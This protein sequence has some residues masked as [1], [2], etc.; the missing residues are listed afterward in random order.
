[1]A[2]RK[3]RSPAAAAAPAPMPASV[4]APVSAPEPPAGAP[5]QGHSRP[6]PLLLAAVLLL[7]PAVGV[8]NE[9]MLQD[10]LKSIVVSFG[11]LGAALVFLLQ[12]R[13]DPQP[14]LWHPVLWLPLLLAAYALGSMAWSHAYLAGVEAIRWFVFALLLWLSLNTLDRARLPVVFWGVH[15]GAVLAAT[16]A[17]LQFWVDWRGFPQG[18]PPASTFVN[19][20]FFAE[21]VVCTLPFSVLLLARLRQ[22]AAIALMAASVALVIV[23]VLMTCTRAA[24]FAMWLQLLIVLP[25]ILWR[26]RDRLAWGGWGTARRA[27]AAGVLLAGVLGMGLVPSGN[28]RLLAEGRGAT[29]LERG[30]KRTAS[31]SAGDASVGIRLLM[32]RTTGRMIADRPLTG[33]GAGAWEVEAPLYMPRD[34]QL[35]ADYYVHNEVL[36]ALAEYGLSGLVFLLGLFAWLLQAAWRTWREEGTDAA[37]EGPWRASALCGLLALLMVSNAGFPW[38]MAATGALFAIALGIVAASDARLRVPGR[39]AP[40]SLR[41]TRGRATAALACAGACTVLAAYIAQQAAACERMIVEAARIALQVSASGRPNAP[42]WAADKARM[43][44]LTREA[45][46]INPHY[47]KITPMVADELAGLGDWQNAAWIWQSVLA[48]RPHVVAIL[49]NVARAHTQLGRPQEAF[50]A[51][52]HAK[53]IS[54]DAPAV[55]SLEVILLSRHGQDARAL[56][57]AGRAMDQ[58]FYDVDLLRNAFLLGWRAGDEALLARSMELLLRDFPAVRPDSLLLLADYQWRGLQDEAKAVESWR[59]ALSTAPAARRPAI[60]AR[61]PPPLRP[62]VER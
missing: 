22:T 62:R 51:L 52:E 39:A 58:G 12:R 45:V 44:Q 15:G 25:W 41:W 43:L 59:L 2:R 19:R 27:L 20:N 56:E 26:Y 8:P 38:R 50:R 28:D 32:W 57:L 53:S 36:Q 37:Q 3:P 6:V 49:T 40:A 17:A 35:E 7:A 4:S 47:R 48:S 23:S 1:M 34:S 9:L 55:R 5:A 11:A 18:P 33:V 42:E 10:T 61:V 29:P 24:L 16:W 21:F 14:V 60:L 30:L 54:P 13:R 46:A 31:L